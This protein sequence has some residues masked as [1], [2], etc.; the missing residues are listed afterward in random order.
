MK[1]SRLLVLN[2]VV[3]LVFGIA[4]LLFPGT[5]VALYGATPG[6]QINVVAQFFGAELV[7][8]GLFAWLARGV[9]DGLA[10]RAIV[11]AFLV[12]DVI[13]LVVSLIGTV[14]GVLNVV[15]WTAVV[16]YAVL[17]FGYANLQFMKPR[18]S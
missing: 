13:G 5:V 15:G 6:P 11:L 16:V 4:F 17:A 7:H 14:S 2:A 18:A 9:A 1:L 10:Q 3:A 8:I 12:G